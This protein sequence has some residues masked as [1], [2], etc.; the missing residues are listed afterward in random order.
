[1]EDILVFIGL[2]VAI[3]VLVAL[4]E[5]RIR[6]PDVLLL[7]ESHEE[8]RIR[9]GLFYPRHFSLRIKRTTIPIRLTLEVT[10]AGNLEVVVKLI[11]SVAPARAHLQA[12]IRVGGWNSDAVS[13]AAEEAQILLQGLV[14]E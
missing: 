4:F 1:M 8:I 9:K 11:G 5:F 7:Y 2:L 14:K 13:R 12:L 3:L 6:Q 10:A